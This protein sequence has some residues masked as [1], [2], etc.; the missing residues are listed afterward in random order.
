MHCRHNAFFID[1]GI[2]KGVER[3][4][5]AVFQ[6]EV[7]MRLD[8]ILNKEGRQTASWVQ[9]LTVH[10]LEELLGE[11][12][13]PPVP[14]DAGAGEVAATRP[15]RPPYLRKNP[16]PSCKKAGASE[17][18]A[19]GSSSSGHRLRADFVLRHRPESPAVG[20]SPA[21]ATVSTV[22]ASVDGPSVASTSSQGHPDINLLALVSELKRLAKLVD[23]NGNPLPLHKLF[24]E[25]N[26][27]VHLILNQLY[28]YSC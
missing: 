7:F 22:G 9:E 10:V 25:G 20:S 16:K 28:T 14:S 24:R 13:D 27:S 15:Q 21:A 17:A 18:S 5:A 2:V 4:V 12:S 6:F 11:E 1:T 3:K 8:K 26:K 23:E 19:T